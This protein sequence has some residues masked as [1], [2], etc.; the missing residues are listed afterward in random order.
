MEGEDAV[1]NHS[2]VHLGEWKEET[3]GESKRRRAMGRRECTGK[4]GKDRS[5]GKKRA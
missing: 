1:A 4:D 3:E 5:F 2:V